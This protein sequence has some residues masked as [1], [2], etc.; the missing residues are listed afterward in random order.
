MTTPEH[1]R[2]VIV[3]TGFAGLGSAIR[4]KQ[5]GEHDFVLLERAERLGGT[6]RDNSYPGC[7]CDVPSHLYSFSFALNPDWTRLCSPQG[8]IQAY[9]ERVAGR[10]RHPAAHPLRPRAAR[11]RLERAAPPVGDPHL[12]RRLHGRDPDQ[13]H[14]RPQRAG[15]AAARGPRVLPGHHLPLRAVGPRALARRRAGGG[16]R[17]GRVRRPVHP[18]DPARSRRAAGLPAHRAV[19][20]AAPQREDQPAPAAPVP[21]LPAG[22][23]ADARRALLERR[24]ARAR[25]GEG[26]APDA[27][28]RA[29]RRKEP[30]APGARPRAAREAQTELPPRLQAHPL[31]RSIPAGARQA[32]RRGRR[33]GHSRSAPALDRHRRRGRAR[34]RHD[35][36]RDRLPRHRP[37]ARRPPARPRRPPAGRALARHDGRVQ[38]HHDHRLPQPV[39]P[40]RPLHRA[41]P[42][43]DRDHDRGP[44]RVHAEGAR[45]DRRAPRRRRSTCARRRRRRSWPR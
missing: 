12:G 14:G 13:R 4:L 19:D 32:E 2:I 20:R 3:G 44:D 24:A 15:A 38:R 33:L 35:H 11:S 37:A 8:E 43:L 40:A 27:D 41:R 45:R 25:A 31:H 39:R 1:H 28:P 9:L 10:I 22:D 29:R 21:A 16:D 7:A 6:W 18:R 30:R 36:L 34:G 5:R 42:H 26:A 17:H 23:E